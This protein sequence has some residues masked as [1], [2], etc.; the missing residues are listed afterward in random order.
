LAKD[1]RRSREASPEDDADVTTGGG[2]YELRVDRRDGTLEL[3][4]ATVRKARIVFL[5]GGQLGRSYALEDELTIGRAAEASIRVVAPGVSRLHARVRRDPRRG[6]VLEDLGSRNGTFLNG[7]PLGPLPL[8]LAFGDRIQLASDVAFLFTRI[9]PAEEHV[10]HLRRMEM[11]G[12]L[13]ASVAHDFNNLLSVMVASLEHLDSLKIDEALPGSDADASLADALAASHDAVAL[14]KRLLSLARPIGDRLRPVSIT[15]AVDDVARMC[16]RVFEPSIHI[17][18]S[19]ESDD[20]TVVAEPTELG[21]IL[22]NLCVNAR[23]AMPTGGT[24]R[25]RAHRMDLARSTAPVPLSGDHVILTV[26]DDGVGMDE[27]TRERIF[28]PFFTTK[29]DVGGSGLGLATVDAAVRRYGGHITVESAP[30][31]GTTFN[32]FL[33][34]VRPETTSTHRL[35]RRSRN[36][37]VIPRVV[38]RLSVL[39]VANEPIVLRAMDRLLRRKGHSVTKSMNLEDAVDQAAGGGFAVMIV[40]GNVLGPG[41]FE[42]LAAARKHVPIVLYASVLP[43]DTQLETQRIGVSAVVAK[44]SSSKEL[45]AILRAAALHAEA[46]EP[47]QG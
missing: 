40:D 31:R 36:T 37:P 17:E 3:P 34:L 15:T 1:E 19:L 21:Q 11:V 47:R 14:S 16:R 42:R 28:D 32:L 10:A 20:F 29:G 24:L 33:P 35:E 44:P 39:A 45:D 18:V 43:E 23:D 38:E 46:T 7:A 4:A 26:E 25:I 22:M 12:R 9:D 8:P 41:A 27:A 5:A 13:A 6:F 30:S 2:D